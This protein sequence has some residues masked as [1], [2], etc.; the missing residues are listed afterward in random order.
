MISFGFLAVKHLYSPLAEHFVCPQNTVL[1][2]IIV[3]YLLQFYFPILKT[4]RHLLGF[5]SNQFIP[6]FHRPCLS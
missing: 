5:P 3:S 4:G 2:E 6:D 1:I